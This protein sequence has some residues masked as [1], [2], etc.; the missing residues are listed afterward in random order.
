[1]Y[2]TRYIYGTLVYIKGTRVIECATSFRDRNIG[3]V[4]TNWIETY[5]PTINS[6]S[7]G[8]KCMNLLQPLKS[9]VL[10]YH[11]GIEQLAA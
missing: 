2:K 7:A 4:W 5:A 9:Y 10:N 3:I 11:Y 1:V 6:V 8:T